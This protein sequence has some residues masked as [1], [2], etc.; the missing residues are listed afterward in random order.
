MRTTLTPE[1]TR[2]IT[3]RLHD[4]NTDFAARYPSET[5]RRQPVH[6]VYG[7]AH[8]FKS[9]TTTRLGALAI[10]ARTRTARF[11]LAVS[12]DAWPAEIKA[13]RPPV[14]ST[15]GRNVS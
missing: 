9:D 11:S 8:L 7:G 4:A 13:N 1:S 5:L 15:G 6:T 10:H 3:A 14:C 12:L 2:E